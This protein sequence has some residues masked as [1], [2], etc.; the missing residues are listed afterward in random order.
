MKKEYLS[1]SV[2]L[3]FSLFSLPPSSAATLDVRAGVLF[4]AEGVIV[5]GMSYDVSFGDGSCISL[6]SGCDEPADFVF[7]DPQRS[8]SANLAV[9][10]QVLIDGPAG[11]FDSNPGL[12]NG[13]YDTANCFILSP[14][15]ARN[16]NGFVSTSIRNRS[17]SLADVWTGYGS[18]P[19][20]DW[21]SGDYPDYPAMTRAN[22]SRAFMV[23]TE[24]PR[25]VPIPGA[26]WLFGS[27]LIG[28]IGVARIDNAKLV[29][30]Y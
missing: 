12:T 15:E 2:L 21:Y 8:I 20:R 19:T 9:L 29:V 6:F 10:E 16:T 24:A 5:D 3:L 7:T 26:V 25:P 28:I 11:L 18:G 23:W 22:Q 27:A 17:G 1:G 30:P 4:G 14:V 13:C